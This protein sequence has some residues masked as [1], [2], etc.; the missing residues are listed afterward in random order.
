MKTALARVTSAILLSLNNKCCSI[1]V[2]I[3]I[4]VAYDILNQNIHLSRTSDI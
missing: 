1:L 2:L 4:S 3:D